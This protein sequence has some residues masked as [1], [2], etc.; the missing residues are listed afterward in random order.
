LYFAKGCF[1]IV[2][3][4]SSDE[5]D[6]AKYFMRGLVWYNRF[7]NTINL[8]INNIE[9][10]CENMLLKSP[11]DNNETLLSIADSFEDEKRFRPLRLISSI[12]PHT[13]GEKILSKELLRTKIQESS[14][15]IIPIVT[16][17][18]TIIT[19]F[20]LPKP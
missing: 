20:F 19:T 10:V 7:K 1:R 11:L 16:I 17:I 18:I 9:K 12:L 2:L 14:D 8:Q 13:E 15:L 5:I 3:N 6:K 4:E